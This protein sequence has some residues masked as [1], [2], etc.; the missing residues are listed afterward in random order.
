MSPVATRRLKGDHHRATALISKARQLLTELREQVERGGLG[1]LSRRVRLHDAV[2]N[3]SI[4]MGQERMEI[5]VPETREE[6]VIELVEPP[7][8]RGV[9]FRK[10]YR[11]DLVRVYL[12]TYGVDFINDWDQA[13]HCSRDWITANY[14]EEWLR[15]RTDEWALVYPLYDTN[16]KWTWVFYI[17][18]H[19]DTIRLL[20]RVEESVGGVS[21]I[22][23][24]FV[25][26]DGIS[27]FSKIRDEPDHE[28]NYAGY[29]LKYSYSYHETDFW[30]GDLETPVTDYNY[31]NDVEHGGG[32]NNWRRV[33]GYTPN[34]P[35][36]E[37]IDG[38]YVPRGIL[39]FQH[40]TSYNA[41]VWT[42][43]EEWTDEDPAVPQFTEEQWEPEWYHSCRDFSTSNLD[44][45]NNDIA[46]EQEGGSPFQF[47]GAHGAE[48]TKIRQGTDEYD[49]TN[50]RDMQKL[51]TLI[52][53]HTEEAEQ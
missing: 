6:M 53:E 37:A 32:H 52:G 39:I 36:G 42:I 24:K 15:R 17:V 38:A 9:P 41:S 51:M 27:D 11:F 1:Q 23:V 43:T 14:G 2:I 26:E 34:P 20:N 30:A 12:K 25:N 49:L 28:V 5:F 21:Y 45:Q 33:D 35:W 46:Y 44:N 16:P 18:P 13:L 50:E 3:V 48:L 22:D 31:R 19:D 10:K 29:E 40:F 7:K 47:E 4:M 8:E